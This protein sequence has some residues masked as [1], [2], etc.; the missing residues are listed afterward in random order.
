[1]TAAPQESRPSVTE[2]E[3]QSDGAPKGGATQD[4]GLDILHVAMNNLVFIYMILHYICIL[5]IYIYIMYTYVYIN[6]CMCIHIYIFMYI[7]IFGV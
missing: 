7:Y 6:M 4:W 2:E 1:M 3:M 5:Y